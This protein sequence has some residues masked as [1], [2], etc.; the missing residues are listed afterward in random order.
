VRETEKGKERGT[1]KG[2][3]RETEKII[4]K[5]N[6]EG[7][8][9]DREKNLTFLVS[10]NFWIKICFWHFFALLVAPFNFWRYVNDGHLCHLWSNWQ[11]DP[12]MSFYWWIDQ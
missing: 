8:F 2:K 5:W 10:A 1:E 11:I 6:R 4:K 7:P 3:E 12:I 9:M